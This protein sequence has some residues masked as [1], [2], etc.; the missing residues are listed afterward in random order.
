MHNNTRKKILFFAEPATLAHVARPTVLAG[1]LNSAQ[2]DVS[3][4]TGTDFKSIASQ[5]GLPVHDLWSIGSKA[6]LAAVNTGQVVFS[7]DV[8]KRY[9]QDDLQLISTLNPDII[10]GDFRLSLAI[11]A[12]LAK[13]PYVGISNAYWSPY[14]HTEYEIPAHLTTQLLG[15]TVANHIFR[16]LRPAI[17]AQH[18]LPMYRLYRKYRM[19]P[20][21]FDLR[22]V[23]TEA[24][25][26]VFADVPEMVPIRDCGVPGRYTYIGPVIWSPEVALPPELA[27]QSKD[28]PLIY[29][30]MGS[31]GDPSLLNTIVRATTSLGYKA[32]V[33]TCGY[34][35]DKSIRGQ[36]VTR[37]FLPGASTA[38]IAKLVICNGGSPSTHQALREG[39]PVL[40]IPANMDQLLNMNFIV[41]TGA[42]LKVRADQVTYNKIRAA[43]QQILNE[44][45][46]SKNAQQVANWFKNCQPKEKFPEIINKISSHLS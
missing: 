32:V 30:A 8:L 22:C 14:A 6:Y 18:S 4:A 40:G 5:T 26:S 3:I 13:I 16:L 2:Y 9:V 12:R 7:Y 44:D 42:G 37:N 21:G 33:A 46:F 20:L 1:T 41:A 11:S 35:L 27:A 23:F 38:A 45:N 25:I 31:S 15:F 28:L 29:I 10:V 19:K 34:L 43:I 17:L 36:I 39:T 24:D